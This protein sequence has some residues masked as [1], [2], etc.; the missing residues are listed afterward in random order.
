MSE[1][2]TCAERIYPKGHFQSYVCSKTAKGEWEGRPVCGRHL[3]MYRRRVEQ[4]AA[5][6][7]E[8][9]KSLAERERHR[10][11]ALRLAGYGI[12]ADQVNGG[13]HLSE[14]AATAL[15]ATLDDW[16]TR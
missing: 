14:D 8:Q 10:A 13:L 5:W 9:A 6:N 1:T 16:V 11:L 4:S 12:T 2:K 7:A 3:A 15:L